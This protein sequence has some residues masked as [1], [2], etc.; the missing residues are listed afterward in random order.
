MACHR[1]FGMTI[2]PA[3][4]NTQ[5]TVPEPTTSMDVTVVIP[6]YNGA[7]FL[8]E[9][10]ASVRNQSAPPR[11][12]IVVDDASQDNSVEIARGLG[13]Q[14][15]A[16]EKNA[17][18]S[19]ARNAGIRLATSE[20]IAF[21]DADDRWRPN[22]LE[23][24]VSAF[25][26]HPEAVLAF[27]QVAQLGE[28][29]RITDLHL[30]NGIPMDLSA[31]LAYENCVPQSGAIAR[32]EMLLETPYDETMRYAEDYDLW[33]RLSR[34]GTMISIDAITLEWRGHENQASKAEV[35]MLDGAWKARLKYIAALGDGG[36]EFFSRIEEA[37]FR[38][39][40]S[41][42]S[43]AWYWANGEL[44]DAAVGKAPVVPHSERTLRKWKR[45]RQYLWNISQRLRSNARKLAATLRRS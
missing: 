27:G 44:F 30:P 29:R 18:P 43:D 21:L 14:V 20:Y 26:P 15:I 40:E 7:R 11:E 34:R 42:L 25:K 32:R 38:G 19:A 33:L 16:L 39:W 45:K 6:C 9:S 23:L 5:D 37:M 36:E 17:G 10:L 2:P 12:I 13:V 41:E 22:H 28:S 31:T 8:E 35:R 3:A 4:T 1:P 24:V